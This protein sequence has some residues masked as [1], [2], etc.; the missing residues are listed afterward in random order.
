MTRGRKL[1]HKTRAQ[2]SLEFIIVAGFAVLLLIA[3]LT[4]TLSQVRS[5]VTEG[6]LSGM[7][8]IALS[9][10]QELLTARSVGDGYERSFTLPADIQGRRYTV[11]LQPDGNATVVTIG[12]AG[13]EISA[14]APRCD[15]T[16]RYG[17]NRITTQNG[18]ISCSV[19]S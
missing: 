13:R 1:H 6:T 14:R 5:A 18:T 15:G 8:D 9:I 19:V 3:L 17:T 4:I 12:L 16:L 11:A 2:V 10:Q 7:E